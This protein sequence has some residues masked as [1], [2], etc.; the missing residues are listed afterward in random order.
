MERNAKEVR[1]PDATG[2]TVFDV[3]AMSRLKG[4]ER[5]ANR[6]RVCGTRA[7]RVL[8]ARS[9][10]RDQPYHYSE[11]RAAFSRSA[12]IERAIVERRAPCSRTA[13]EST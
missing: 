1:F 9:G 8:G 10:D 2:T 11:D 3:S 6:M 4:N 5:R 13:M 7:K 12:W